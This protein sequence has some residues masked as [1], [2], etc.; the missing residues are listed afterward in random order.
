[1]FLIV[2]NGLCMCLFKRLVS[3]KRGKWDDLAMI[4]VKFIQLA[5][6]TL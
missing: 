6:R 3:P 1:M 4:K 5:L 2:W